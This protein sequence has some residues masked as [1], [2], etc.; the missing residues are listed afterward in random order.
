MAGGAASLANKLCQ[1]AN[2][3]VYADEKKVVPLHERK[4]DMLEDLLEAAN[5]KPVLIAYWFKHDLDRISGRLNKLHIP[6][7]TAD[8][9]D[10]IQRW[11]RGE[12][13]V[14]L[15]HPASAGHGLNLQ[16]GGCTLVWFGLTSGIRFNSSSPPSAVGW[17]IF[18]AA[19]TVCSTRCWRS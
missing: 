13:P 14:M 4:L 17:A 19:V 16:S 12:L 2:G 10:S 18:S 8:K 3:A 1:M 5:G 11:N 7:A 15:I 9:T 6:F